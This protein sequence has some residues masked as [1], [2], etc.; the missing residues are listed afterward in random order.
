MLSRAYLRR[1]TGGRISVIVDQSGSGSV[2]ARRS[3][4]GDM[5]RP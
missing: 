1:A 4:A 2:A 3:F 5:V